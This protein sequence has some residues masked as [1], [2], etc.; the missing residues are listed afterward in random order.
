[1]RRHVIKA[2]PAAPQVDQVN[3]IHGAKHN[4]RPSPDHGVCL[5]RVFA[6]LR[7]IVFYRMLD[8]GFVKHEYDSY[9]SAYVEQG[10]G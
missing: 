1:M 2:P 7:L 3:D 4:H 8:P 9:R 6:S 5:S 10:N